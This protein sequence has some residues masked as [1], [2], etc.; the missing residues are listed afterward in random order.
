MVLTAMADNSAGL[1]L[2]ARTGFSRVGIY[3]EQGQLDGRW[4]D[5]VVMEKL[6]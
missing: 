4:V 2:Y 3:R 5:V 6:L 1:S